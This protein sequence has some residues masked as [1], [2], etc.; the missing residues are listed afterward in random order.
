MWNGIYEINRHTV[1][2]AQNHEKWN[3]GKQENRKPG[4][5]NFNLQISNATT[6]KFM[7]STISEFSIYTNP[8]NTKKCLTQNHISSTILNNW[9]C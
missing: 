5:R 9:K 3:F 6:I 7:N 1:Q 4:K 2:V 8:Q